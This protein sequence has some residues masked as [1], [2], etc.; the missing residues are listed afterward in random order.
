MKKGKTVYLWFII[1]FF[2][3]LW[4]PYF[5]NIAKPVP[6]AFFGGTP[7]FLSL[8]PWLLICGIVE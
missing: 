1:L 2:I 3:V 6:I 5:Q 7:P 8:Y 4:V